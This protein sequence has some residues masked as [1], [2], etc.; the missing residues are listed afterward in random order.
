[1][2]ELA[3]LKAGIWVSACLSACRAAAVPA[4]VL[5]KGDADAGT[6]I[7]KWRRPDG[8]GGALV[9]MPTL[10]AGREWRLATGARPVVET[11]VDAYWRR[12]RARD[13]D[14]WVLE[15][16]SERLWHPLG[17][18][19]VGAKVSHDPTQAAALFRR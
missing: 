16:E 6:V 17:E 12:Q 13:P 19:L 9:A 4:T 11:E 1:L 8:L 10:D 14:V 15:I 18:A 7:L 2:H 5:A 3:S